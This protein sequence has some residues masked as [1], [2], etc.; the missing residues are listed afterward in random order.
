M[1][2]SAL[3]SL[4]LLAA[5]ACGTSSANPFDQ[6]RHAVGTYIGGGSFLRGTS[7]CTYE[8]GPRVFMPN[9]TNTT[10]SWTPDAGPRFV[11]APGRIIKRCGDSTERLAAVEPTGAVIDGP[12]K[13]KRGTTSDLYTAQ[14]IA[15]GLPLRGDAPIEWHLGQDCAGITEFAPVMGAQDTG[16]RD[17]FRQ[18]IA[19]GKG[20]CTLT[21]DLTLGSSLAPSF[22]PRTFQTHRLITIE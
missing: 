10:P 17:R 11:F 16:G 12:A 8:G 13:I 20:T 2:N 4:S 15:N 14:L 19:N 18:L 22:Q 3:L 1:N 5:A 7:S 21:V 6:E 9:G